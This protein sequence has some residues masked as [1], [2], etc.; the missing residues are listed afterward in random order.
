MP[1]FARA[2]VV[3]LLIS[4]S[5]CSGSSSPTASTPPP[6]T[7]GNL[8][9]GVD[10][11]TCFRVTQIAISVDAVLWGTVNPGDAGVSQQVAIGSHSISGV[12]LVT[13]G[14]T[15]TWKPAIVSVPAAGFNYT[16][17]CTDTGGVGY[18]MPR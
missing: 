6:P 8:H 17:P 7:T 18:H 11:S 9:V 2:C 13:I 10:L 1:M 4:V 14:G 15:D 5:A 16:M 12:G 3:L